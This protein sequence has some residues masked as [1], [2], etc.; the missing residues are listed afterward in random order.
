MRNKKSK[1]TKNNFL[2]FKFPW[3]VGLKNMTVE[4]GLLEV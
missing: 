1:H 4:F 2:D 3:N